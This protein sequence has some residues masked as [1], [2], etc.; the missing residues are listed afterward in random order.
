[1]NEY[2]DILLFLVFVRRTTPIF[3]EQVY[4]LGT[5]LTDC[6]LLGTAF[7]ISQKH[8]VTAMHVLVDDV[9]G[10]LLQE[11]FAIGHNA[12]RTELHGLEM[13]N[14]LIVKLLASDADDD[15]AILE[16]QGDPLPSF[17]PIC[18]S[19]Q[20]PTPART[21]EELKV[22][23]A[24]IGMFLSSSLD[25]LAMWTDEYKRVLQYHCLSTRI[26]VAGGLYRGSCGAPYINH[27][28]FVVG[29]HIA[30]L[31]ESK[32]KENVSNVKSKKRTLQD[33]LTE[34]QSEVT[35]LAAVHASIK[36]GV[37]LRN[38]VS[39]MKALANLAVL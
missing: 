13:E 33:Q 34:V 17:I 26:L 7:S 30:S 1:M 2:Y 4:A 15:W 12:K 5:A 19:D 38:C 29:M 11:I 27:D 35:D 10:H 37:V 9:N 14:G 16:I 22:I 18:P 21:N 25:E 24:P 6:E 20:L 3:L 23:Y 31:N 39:F 36:E 8:V 28:G 32:E